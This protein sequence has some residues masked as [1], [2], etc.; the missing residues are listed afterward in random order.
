NL[1]WLSAA[2]DEQEMNDHPA[3][4]PIC[5]WVLPNNLDSSLMIYD[6]DGK[7]LGSINRNAQWEPTPASPSPMQPSD[8][9][10]SHLNKMVMTIIR[11]GA[12]FLGHFISAIDNA[13]EKIE[14]ENYAQHQ[15]L[16]LLI[17]R[18][19]ALVRAALNLELQGL[20]TVHQGWEAFRQD[21]QRI[22]R[23]TS[24]FE[25][26]E[27]PVHIGEYQQFNDGLVGYWKEAGDAYEDDLF[28]A[29]Q[30]DLSEDEQITTHADETA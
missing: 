3:T 2:Q 16:A 25:H 30:T 4:T 10:N 28:Y 26:V 17:G 18:P 22:N 11:L 7:A 9:S 5:G 21:L 8:I 1:R 24:H 27:F 12:D 20:P 23:E 19:L 14:P 15:D 6:G 13:L 29:P